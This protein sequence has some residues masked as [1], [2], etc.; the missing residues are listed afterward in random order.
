MVF[1]Y[2]MLLHNTYIIVRCIRNFSLSKMIVGVAGLI[3]IFIGGCRGAI[4]ILVVVI[5]IM[6]ILKSD[7]NIKIVLSILAIGVLTIV[8]MENMN[9][10]VLF[11]DRY[12]VHFGINSRTIYRI[13]NGSFADDTD[14][15]RIWNDVIKNCGIFGKGMFSDRLFAGTYSHNLFI[16]LICDYGWIVGIIMS[17]YIIFVVAKAFILSE[18]NEKDF[19]MA[20][21]SAGLFKLMLSSSYLNQEPALYAAIGFSLY[22]IEKNRNKQKKNDKEKYFTYI[23]ESQSRL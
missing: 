15:F 12:L 17:V 16:E 18:N 6:A 2:G 8:L 19:L 23:V 20:L 5:L 14:R 9:K 13:M 3:T 1:S 22:I 4:L 10:L 11:I 21:A 7:R